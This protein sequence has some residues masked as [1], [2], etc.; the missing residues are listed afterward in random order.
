MLHCSSISRK[1][2][3]TI[4]L[5]PEIGGFWNVFNAV[6]GLGNRLRGRTQRALFF[7]VDSASAA[8]CWFFRA[9]ARLGALVCQFGRRLDAKLGVPAQQSLCL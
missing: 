5:V 1:A 3:D 4:D 8:E 6:V 9:S 7:L 2:F